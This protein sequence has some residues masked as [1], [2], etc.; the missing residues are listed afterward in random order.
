[1]D[2]ELRKIKKRHNN[3]PILI[4]LTIILG[5]GLSLGAIYYIYYL[6]DQRQN[7]L[8]TGLISIDFY[9][10]SNDINLT[11]V[12]VIDEVGINNT[13][14]TFTIT[15]TSSVTIDIKILLDINNQTNIDLEAVKYA[16]YI[17]NTLMEKGYV[18]PENLVIHTKEDVAGNETINCKIVFWVDYY[19]DKPGKIF[20]TKITAE[21]ISK[22]VAP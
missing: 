16:F 17:D 21:G 9:E 13:P 6:R 20:K 11:T 1:M 14:Y 3:L 18:N 10:S 19:Y 5:L 22:D 4:I 7:D 15:N 12:P 2:I 8:T